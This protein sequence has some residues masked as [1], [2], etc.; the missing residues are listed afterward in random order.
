VERG[1]ARGD[2]QGRS[3]GGD[4]K[5]HAARLPTQLQWSGCD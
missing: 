5:A 3:D 2:R 4:G 1:R